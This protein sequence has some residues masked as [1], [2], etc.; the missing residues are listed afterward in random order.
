LNDPGAHKV[1]K[2]AAFLC[3]GKGFFK[4]FA[5]FPKAPS[6]DVKNPATLK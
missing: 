6:D 3:V 4:S 1:K 2:L 5:T